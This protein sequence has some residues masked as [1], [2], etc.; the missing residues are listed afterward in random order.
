MAIG[1]GALRL[2]ELGTPKMQTTRENGWH[3]D[4]GGGW[5]RGFSAFARR[6]ERILFASRVARSGVCSTSPGTG[7]E[8]ENSDSDRQIFVFVR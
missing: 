4:G 3:T 5:H 2:K 1:A 7:P 6:E 8:R